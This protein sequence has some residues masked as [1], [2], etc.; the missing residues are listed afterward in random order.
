MNNK[1]RI[2]RYKNI[3]NQKIYIRFDK[4]SILIGIQKLLAHYSPKMTKVYA[5][6][7]G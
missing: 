7:R 4:E 3:S 5:S 2:T 1:C 6:F